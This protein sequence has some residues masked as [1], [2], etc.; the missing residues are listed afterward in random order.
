MSPGA[1]MMSRAAYAFNRAARY[2]AYFGYLGGNSTLATARVCVVC[3]VW[4]SSGS[5]LAPWLHPQTVCMKHVTGRF[6]GIHL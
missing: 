6:I 5:T 4:R 1:V 3:Q 2:G